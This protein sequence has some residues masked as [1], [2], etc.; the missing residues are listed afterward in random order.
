MLQHS[1]PDNHLKSIGDITV[2]F[3]LLEF[4]L[5]SLIRSQLNERQRIGQIITAELSFKGLKALLVSLY[6]ERH[7]KD[8]ADFEKL[9]TLIN[10][11]GQA[12]EKRNQITHSIWGAG[13]D[14]DSITRIKTTAKEK[15][16]IRSQFEDVSSGDL[17]AFAIEIKELA[18]EIQNF[19]IYLIKNGKAINSHE[20]HRLP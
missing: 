9:K 19:L 11:A 12:E 16:G 15:H 17:E 7:G 1:V 13:K 14:A 8:D 4:Q 5:Q 6:I 2:S 3:A 18:H 10:R 20:T